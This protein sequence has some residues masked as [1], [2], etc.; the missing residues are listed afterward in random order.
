MPAQQT[1][2]ILLNLSELYWQIGSA[3]SVPSN[4]ERIACAVVEANRITYDRYKRQ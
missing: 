1:Y 3:A 4:C 2:E